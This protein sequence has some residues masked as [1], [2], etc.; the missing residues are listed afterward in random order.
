MKPIRG[1]H[2]LEM[3]GS[4][5]GA[6]KQRWLQTIHL[7]ASG[8]DART[9]LPFTGSAAAATKKYKAT[10]SIPAQLPA[11]THADY[12]WPANVKVLFPSERYVTTVC[13][14]GVGSGGTFYG[15]SDAFKE[16]KYV[17]VLEEDNCILILFST[18]T[19]TATSTCFIFRRASERPP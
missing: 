2:V 12:M 10:L 18:A 8:H 5:T 4:S 17:V 6:Y 16:N 19:C 3:Q 11:D 15:K 7:I 9:C 13:A 1:G 14:T